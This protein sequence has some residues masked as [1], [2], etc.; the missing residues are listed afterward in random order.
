MDL[1]F[2]LFANCIPVRGAKRSVICD[3]Q[4][5]KFYFIPNSLYDILTIYEGA[6]VAAIENKLANSDK[7]ILKDYFDFLLKNEL[8]FWCEV[9][10]VDFFSKI[11]L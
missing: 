11:K 8:I 4:R 10:E 7:I 1:V 9:S 2:K 5:N 6:E 3:L